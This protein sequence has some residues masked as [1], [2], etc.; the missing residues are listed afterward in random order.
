M[1]RNIKDD[2]LQNAGSTAHN[3]VAQTWFG[4]NSA[5]FCDGHEWAI[6][7]H[8]A[9]KDFIRNPRGWRLTSPPANCLGTT[10]NEKLWPMSWRVNWPGNEGDAK[11]I[12]AIQ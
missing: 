3:Y 2:S 5:G 7:S 9:S 12:E 6:P 4:E 11:L 10:P 1:S 8:D